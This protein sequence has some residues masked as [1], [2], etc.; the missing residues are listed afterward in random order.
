M[1]LIRVR[2]KVQ[3]SGSHEPD[4]RIPGLYETA[5]SEK[6]L[7]GLTH[8]HMCTHLINFFLKHLE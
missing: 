6:V 4:S 1:C 5:G 7:F 8:S 3:E 2:A